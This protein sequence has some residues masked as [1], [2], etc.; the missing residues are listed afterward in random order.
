MESPSSLDDRI[1]RFWD[2]YLAVLNKGGIAPSA[3]R[4]Y[5]VRVE[6][7]VKAREGRKLLDHRADDVVS[8]LRAVGRDHRLE[9]WQMAQVVHALHLLFC[10][11]LG[12]P[13]CGEVDWSYWKTAFRELQPDH[14]TKDRNSNGGCPGSETLEARVRRDRSGGSLG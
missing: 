6:E 12:V 11:L 4:G 9:S 8:Y 14:P 1:A 10:Q 13:W 7:Y 2:R 5:V 3:A